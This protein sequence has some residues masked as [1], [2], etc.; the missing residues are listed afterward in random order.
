LQAR[1]EMAAPGRFAELE[2]L[3]ASLPS[4]HRALR[5][6][7]EL[8]GSGPS[9]LAGVPAAAC[10]SATV[11]AQAMGGGMPAAWPRPEVAAL[12]GVSR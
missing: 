5:W 8:P 10:A 2:P 1:V 6:L 12:C 11:A 3:L 4:L 9:S 7:S